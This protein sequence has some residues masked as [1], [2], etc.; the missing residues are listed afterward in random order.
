[1]VA[2][3]VVAHSSVCI[4][5]VGK[6]RPTARWLLDSC[7]LMN[8]L[9]LLILARVWFTLYSSFR[10]VAK[11]DKAALGKGLGRRLASHHLPRE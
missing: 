5:S 2:A 10:V 1:V 3:S 7:K 4:G 11:S 8:Q 6:S 9:V